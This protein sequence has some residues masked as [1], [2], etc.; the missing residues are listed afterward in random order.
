MNSV[1]R[2]LY[3]TDTTPQESAAYIEGAVPEDWPRE[4]A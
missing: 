2:I 3:Y 4:G 1:E